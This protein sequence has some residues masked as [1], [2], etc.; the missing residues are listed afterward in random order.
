MRKI[1]TLSIAVVLAL[2]AIGTWAAATTGS[3]ERVGFSGERI[4]TLQ[5]M[6]V[7]TNLPAEQYEA[8]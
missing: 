7:S 6:S 8:F 2:V 4:N 5:L 1:M 3:Q